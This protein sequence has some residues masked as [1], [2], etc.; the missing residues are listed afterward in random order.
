VVVGASSLPDDRGFSQVVA[1]W[2]SELVAHLEKHK[3]YP[4]E[5]KPRR[6]QGVAQ[7]FFSIDRKGRL[8][9][10]RV[11]RSSGSRVLDKE[12]LAVP[13]RAVPFPPPALLTGD[14]VELTVPFRSNF[15]EHQSSR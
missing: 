11:V 3:R 1:P 2:K 7:V 15:V 9:E 13:Q 5:A 8:L 12:A 4:E 6:E 14:H 10:S